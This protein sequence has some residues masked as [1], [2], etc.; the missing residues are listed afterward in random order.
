MILDQRITD[1]TIESSPEICENKPENEIKTDEQI[2]LEQE[3]IMREQQEQEERE[4]RE[5]ELELERARLEEEKRQ[6]E[7]RIQR[8]LEEIEAKNKPFQKIPQLIE[9]FFDNLQITE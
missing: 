4:R 6:E 1:A 5:R 9:V 3:R 8:E 2:R 7:L